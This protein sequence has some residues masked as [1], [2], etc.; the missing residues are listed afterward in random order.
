MKNGLEKFGVGFLLGLLLIGIIALTL[1][2]N[3][4]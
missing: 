2:T 4:R 1:V 3:L